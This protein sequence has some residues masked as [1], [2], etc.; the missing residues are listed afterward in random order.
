MSSNKTIAAIIPA[1]YQS[2]RL[3]GK[4]LARIGDKAMV[5]HVYDK[6]FNSK[7]FN[8]VVVATDDEKIMQYCL[9]NK[10]ECI[11]TRKD[12]ISGTDRCIEVAAAIDADIY[13]NIQGDEP[14]IE[15]NNFEQLL[16]VITN[17]ESVEIATLARKI[18]DQDELFDPSKVKVVMSKTQM[19]MYFSRNTIPYIRN[20][21]KDKWLSQ[22]EFYLHIGLYAFTHSAL[23][24][25]GHLKMG[26]LENVEMLEQLRWLENDMKIAIAL[27][28]YK[29][30]GIDTPEDLIKANQM[31]ASNI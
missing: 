11:M 27:T 15:A 14:F 9:S 2:T 24:K 29:G 8:K 10:I 22:T 5:H 23:S 20:E 7:L 31:F 16:S 13:V 17:N 21:S 4:P 12:H 6:A 3:P 18:T 19:A 25:I 26:T 28:E 30:M 1:R